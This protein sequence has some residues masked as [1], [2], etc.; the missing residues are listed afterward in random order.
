MRL[1]CNLT[2]RSFRKKQRSGGDEC[3]FYCACDNL[4]HACGNW[5]AFLMNKPVKLL[6]GCSRQRSTN[7]FCHLVASTGRTPVKASDSKG[8]TPATTSHFRI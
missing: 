4:F 8:R 3:V 1:Y 6:I 2:Q 7:S 5:S